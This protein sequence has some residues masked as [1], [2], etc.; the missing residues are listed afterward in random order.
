MIH[1]EY[2]KDGTPC[3]CDF[4]V[5]DHFSRTRALWCETPYVNGKKHG[6]E[7]W[8]YYSGAL[9][10]KSPYVNNKKQGTEEVYYE[11]GALELATS[12]ADD[13]PHGI[14]KQYNEFG[15]LTNEIF[16]FHGTFVDDFFVSPIE[17]YV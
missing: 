11:S 13:N 1:T 9:H 4:M 17:N 6:I 5:R 16:F 2:Y 8:Y 12:Y 7:R 10:A 3:E 15:V 14:E